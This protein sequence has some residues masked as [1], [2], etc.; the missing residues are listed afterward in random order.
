MRKLLLLI[1][2]AFAG[3][4]NSY[5]QESKIEYGNNLDAGHYAEVNGIKLYYEVYGEGDPLLLIHGNGGSIR[6]HAGKIEYFKKKYKV[7][8]TDSRAHG[9]TED[10]GDSLTYKNMTSD[11]NELLNL[12]KIDSCYIW[13]QSD[14]GIIGLRLAMDFPDKVKKLAIFGANLKPD[15][16]AVHK[17]IVN[18][19]DENSKK[20]KDNHEK[21]LFD[22]LKFQPQI[23]YSELGKIQIPVLIMSGD[24]DAI[25]LEHS[26]EIF[27]HIENSNLFIMPGATHF[28]SYEKPDLFNLILNDFFTKPFSKKATIDIFK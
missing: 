5:G 19:V 22:L 18:W 2:I 7:I 9:K 4:L 11:I 27:N 16:S 13:G 21:R 25:R 17:S 26:V 15:T 12:L 28:G 20:T 14:G 24:R 3:I 8:A 6:G 23:E 10:I 1:S